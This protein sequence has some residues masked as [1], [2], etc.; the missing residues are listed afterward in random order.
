MGKA[1]TGGKDNVTGKPISS[2][3]KV[4]AQMISIF[5]AWILKAPAFK[6]DLP[7]SDGA[8]VTHAMH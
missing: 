6:G 5:F 3:I 8:E 2:N 1:K 4:S 7:K